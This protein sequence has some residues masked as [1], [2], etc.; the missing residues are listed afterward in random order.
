MRT[1]RGL[2]KIMDEIIDILK[3]DKELSVRQLSIK[4]KSQWATAMKALEKLKYYQVVKE[5]LDK[6]NG[7]KSRMFSLSKKFG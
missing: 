2:T 3:K 4:T 1:Y 6:N 5:R 7:K